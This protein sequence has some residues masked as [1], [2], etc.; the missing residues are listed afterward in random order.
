MLKFMKSP[1]SK[2][3]VTQFKT[4][5]KS[6]SF[7]IFPFLKGFFEFSFYFESYKNYKKF[8]KNK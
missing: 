6:F 7:Q 8:D 5:V 3:I 1:Q 2:N 4:I